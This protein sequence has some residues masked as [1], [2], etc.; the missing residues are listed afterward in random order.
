MARTKLYRYYY[1]N[2]RITIEA[3]S[4]EQASAKYRQIVDDFKPQLKHGNDQQVRVKSCRRAKISEDIEVLNAFDDGYGLGYFKLPG[5]RKL[6]KAYRTY[7]RSKAARQGYEA[8]LEDARR[9]N[10][11]KAA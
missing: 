4:Q 3:T 9:D 10:R 11:K 1:K 2:T 6:Q 5:I 8:G 7:E